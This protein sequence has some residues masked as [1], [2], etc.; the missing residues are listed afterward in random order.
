MLLDELLSVGRAAEDLSRRRRPRHRAVVP[1]DALIVGVTSLRSQIFVPELLRYR[2]AGHSTLA[3]VIDTSDLLP[4]AESRTEA[5][6]LRIWIAQR[7]AE[8]HTLERGGI[9]TAL[10]TADDG[11]GPAVLTL[12]RRMAALQQ[13]ARAGVAAR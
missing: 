1:A 4:A 8:R 11:V 7:E 13:P 12:R 10:V 9:P 6:A 2:R 5:A 3:L